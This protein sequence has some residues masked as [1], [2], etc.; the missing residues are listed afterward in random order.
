MPLDRR[1]R[2]A[3]RLLTAARARVALAA[4]M[5]LASG[6][7]IRALPVN[8]D[9][10]GHQ[11]MTSVVL[12]ADGSQLT[13]L[14]AEQDR[15]ILP[16]EKIPPILVAAVVATEDRRF[17]SHDGID[18]RGLARAAVNDARSGTAVEGGST[19]T[20]QLVKNTMTSKDR[21]LSRKVREAS[22][23]VGLEKSLTKAQILERYLNTVYFGEG[24]YGVGAAIRVYYGHS[25]QTLSVADAAMLAGLVRSPNS[26][27][28]IRHPQRAADRRSDVL[29][30]M[31]AAGVITTADRDTAD[32]AQLPTKV[33]K[34]DS[35]YPAAYAVTDAIEELRA[36]TRLGTTQAERDNAIY[37]GGLTIKLTI[38][39]HIQRAA[40]AALAATLSDPT[41]PD[42]AI[43]SVRPGDG[44]IT[45]MVGGRDFFST[46]DPIAKVNLATGGS[47]KRQ[48]GST[49]KMFTIVA[50][51]Q[52][53]MSPDDLFEAGGHAS[54]SRGGTRTWEVDNYDGSALGE[55]SLRTAT[56][57][58]VNT[59][60]ARIVTK[61]G[62]GD[63]DAGARKVV[64]VAERFGITGA[65]DS[66]LR[67]G[68]AT[69]LG[70]QEVD[71]VQ[72]A[73][74]YAAL[75][76]GGLYNA[77]YLVGWVKDADG[78]FLIKN[79]PHPV[80]V[81][82]PAT[83]AV[84]TDLLRG[85][86]TAG[87]GF[88]AAINR[89]QAGKTGTSTNYHD[90]W[91]V[92]YTPDFAAA[93]WLGVARRQT[94]MTKAHGFRMTISGGTL[95]AEAWA[96]FASAALAGVPPHDFAV[97]AASLVA[98]V[99]DISRRCLPNDW[100]PV[101]LKQPRTY[102]KGAEPTEV[103]T[104][105]HRPDLLPTPEF[106]GLGRD[107]AIEVA[108]TYELQLSFVPVYGTG[109][110]VGQVLD[111]SPGAG[112]PVRSGATVT[113]RVV[114]AAGGATVVPNVTG[115]TA[116][117][118]LE[119]LAAAGLV[120]SV[121]VDASCTGDAVCAETLTR[122][123]GLVWQQSLVAGGAAT[124]GTAI[125]LTIEPAAGVV[126]PS[127]PT[128]SSGPAPTSAPAPAPAPTDPG[129]APSTSASTA[130]VPGPTVTP[131]PT[132]AA[133]G[134]QVGG[135]PSIQASAG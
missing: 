36:D 108:T 82:D 98:V 120:G 55:I 81:T 113:L 34:D 74:A 106:T 48:A 105:P 54:I 94:S 96:R 71:P 28:P 13:T 122:N 130:T 52:A 57:K 126:D 88:R 101:A 60:F 8:P 116:A 2:A 19:I 97:T 85:V 11:A 56:E 86:V 33:F 51:L 45:A 89:P 43:A 91:F 27:D 102:V 123:A 53:G 37:R 4:V 63:P 104:E 14:H 87:T 6:G 21:T 49:F 117:L 75:A 119:R 12:A 39:P 77:P 78:H 23:A 131:A 93:V 10:L 35:R 109:A 73:A 32:A 31:V 47:T 90:A 70:A 100:T 15:T 24:A 62:N 64:A 44:A 95:P 79:T 133:V 5:T 124:E 46:K 18:M 129:P 128:F 3:R 103:C 118:A 1:R 66:A 68:P 22:L 107:A 58:S 61:L 110:A 25:P 99:V 114:G 41:D 134:A 65:G 84:A 92:G 40:E 72:M 20:Q 127:W 38:D 125:Q 115:L 17:F 29:R 121:V 16:L 7:C 135:V 83:A 112:T 30:D 69:T 50:A 76:S 67:T 9:L 132:A 59:A 80:R 26:A 111:Q 42:G